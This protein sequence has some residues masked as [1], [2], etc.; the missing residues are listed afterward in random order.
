[1][2][3]VAYLSSRNILVYLG[4]HEMKESLI[5]KPYKVTKHRPGMNGLTAGFIC[6]IILLYGIVIIRLIMG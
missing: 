4:R 3:F 1:M 2:V 5:G 6:G